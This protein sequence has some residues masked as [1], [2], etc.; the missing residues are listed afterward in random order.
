MIPLRVFFLFFFFCCSSNITRLLILEIL[1]LFHCRPVRWDS[2]WPPF[3]KAKG[4]SPLIR[5]YTSSHI[6]LWVPKYEVGRSVGRFPAVCASKGLGFM[7][8]CFLACLLIGYTFSFSFFF[9]FF[10]NFLFL[11]LL[12]EG[13]E[14]RLY[15]RHLLAAF[16]TQFFC[17]EITDG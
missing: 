5:A 10:G 9:F 1:H 11:I 8:E 7:L 4:Y 3:S 14:L 6:F 12:S 17:L 2:C 15:P 13:D 16:R